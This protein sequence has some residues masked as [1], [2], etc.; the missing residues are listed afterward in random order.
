MSSKHCM[1]S[2]KLVNTMGAVVS[3]FAYDL[4]ELGLLHMISI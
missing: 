4:G 3:K 1:I 2:P